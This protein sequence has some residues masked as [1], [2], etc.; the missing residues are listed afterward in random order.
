MIK[1]IKNE[2]FKVFHKKST[3]IVLVICLAFISL[4]TFIN[5]YVDID[6][7]IEYAR[8]A[9]DYKKLID[10]FNEK[11]ESLEDLVYYETMNELDNLYKTYNQDTWQYY[12]INA[13][14]FNCLDNYYRSKYIEK[15]EEAI[16]KYN[17]TIKNLK[18]NNWQY[19]VNQ[20][21]D[22]VKVDIRALKKDLKTE[23][24]SKENKKNYEQNLFALETKLETLEYRINNNLSYGNDYLNQAIETL[25]T[26]AS[27][28]DKDSIG[29]YE[30]AKYILDTKE[31]IEN[32]ANLYSM[33]KTFFGNYYFLIILFIV[34]ISGSIVSDEFNK[35]TIKTLLVSPYKRSSILLS[36]FITCLILILFIIISLFVFQVVLG[37]VLFG[38]DSLSIHAVEYNATMSKLEVMNIFK[39]WSLNFLAELPLIILLST[40]AFALSTILCST[41]FSIAITLCGVI[42]SQI[43]NLFAVNYKIK[44]LN[45][46][47]TTN[48][49][50][51][52]YLFG[53]RNPF[54]NSLTHAIVVCLVYFF[55]MIIT[56]FIIFNRK[57][58]KNI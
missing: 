2:L 46:F 3:Y 36:K 26:T 51:T 1:L 49:D 14:M 29:D 6:H 16:T 45:Y 8:E 25:N 33:I 41:A 44:I 54:G 30:K 13:N 38:F 34:M 58:V 53:G 15:D 11:N 22:S 31:D 55:V 37:G 52:Y 20:D 17:L 9:V 23:N 10:N 7:T 40:L 56:S 18:E 19:F 12:Y 48:W 24:L 5:R 21:I 27:N 35:G 4:I 43:I 42:G 32:Q 28:Y 39:Y 47:V 50:F 57:N